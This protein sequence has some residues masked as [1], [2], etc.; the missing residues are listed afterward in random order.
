MEQI[1]QSLSHERQR[2][3]QTQI[4]SEEEAFMKMWRGLLGFHPSFNFIRKG[5]K[6]FPQA[7]KIRLTKTTVEDPLKLESML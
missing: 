3:R 5:T 2:S 4:L 1:S 7:K 6:S